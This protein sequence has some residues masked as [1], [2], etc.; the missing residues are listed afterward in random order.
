MKRI[1]PIIV[2]A[3][4]LI[5]LGDTM[6]HSAVAASASADRTVEQRILIKHCYGQYRGQDDIARCL[7]RGAI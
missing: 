6:R 1:A 4:A 7:A 3:L 2:L 5:P